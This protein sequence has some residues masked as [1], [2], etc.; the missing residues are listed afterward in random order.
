MFQNIK[1]DIIY[2]MTQ[3]DFEM[4]FNLSGCC[5]M[6]LL[7]DKAPDRKIL[8]NQ[9]VR[10][11]S[12]SRIILL[13]GNLFG[14]NGTITTCAKAIGRELVA[15]DNQRF[16]I[17]SQDDIEIISNSIPLV[18]ADGIFA[19]CVVEQ[20][21]QT[22]ILLTDNKNIR[23]NVMQNLVHQYIK[24]ICANEMTDKDP[25]AESPTAKI[26]TAVSLQAETINNLP[27]PQ[28]DTE[29]ITDELEPD[30]EVDSSDEELQNDL[31]VDEIEEIEEISEPLEE[32]NVPNVSQT[33]GDGIYLGDDLVL[34]DEPS[35]YDNYSDLQQD[36]VMESDDV[37]FENE[38]KTVSEAI[39]KEA[40]Q[41]DALI[42]EDEEN[43]QISD[44]PYSAGYLDDLAVDED[45]EIEYL[46]NGGINIPILVLAI[47]LLGLALILFYCIFFVP[48]KEGIDAAQYLKEVFDILFV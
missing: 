17:R 1:V 44:L 41:G 38:I 6:R 21:P 3:T 10:A 22:L 25:S 18:S 40:Q 30:G 14:K 8:V 11:V 46:P 12:R 24:D 19:G 13:T 7:T 2:Y 15:V 31:E 37:Y 28:Q 34:E 9:L 33:S 29:S 45:D 16:G 32:D 43:L 5:R 26:A 48:A 4:E 39:K 36:I 20:G 27:Q 42:F 23:K 35:D 47:I